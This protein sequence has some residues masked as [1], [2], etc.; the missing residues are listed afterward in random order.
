MRSNRRSR[1]GNKPAMLTGALPQ[2]KAGWARD[3]IALAAF[4]LGLEASSV[5]ESVSRPP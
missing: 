4:E 5:S 1:P 2:R 3:P